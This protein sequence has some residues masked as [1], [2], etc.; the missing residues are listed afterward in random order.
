MVIELDAGGAPRVNEDGSIPGRAASKLISCTE[1][2]SAD[3]DAAWVKKGKKSHFGYCSYVRVDSNDGYIR[4]LH[5]APANESETPHLQKALAACD[6]KPA[7]V[8]AVTSGCKLIQCS[9]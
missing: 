3:P 6:F 5:T 7:R 2:W 4:G 8:Y 1:T 9:D